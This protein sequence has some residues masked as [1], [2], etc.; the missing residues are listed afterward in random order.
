VCAAVKH[1]EVLATCVRSFR[2]SSSFVECLTSKVA[3]TCLGGGATDACAFLLKEIVIPQAAHLRDP[4]YR[5]PGTRVLL[6]LMRLDVVRDGLRSS[7]IRSLG[8]PIHFWVERAEFWQERGEDL[9][10]TLRV[11][12]HCLVSDVHDIL[13]LLA[14]LV[15]H[16]QEMDIGAI[17]VVQ[18]D[19]WPLCSSV[20]PCF[21]GRDF[22]LSGRRCATRVRPV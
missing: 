16:I 1:F 17:P 22:E 14:Q 15:D 4:G 2:L 6:H 8:N 20:A 12:D 5:E 9:A 13:S 3:S 19:V 21:P 10:E 7:V 18:P 11:A